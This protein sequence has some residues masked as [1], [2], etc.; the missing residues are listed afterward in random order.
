MNAAIIT[1]REGSK[2]ILDKNL[3]RI[4]GE[5]LISYPVRAAQS[6]ATVSRIF[7]STDGKK[8]AR[9]AEMLGCEVIWRPESVSG[10]GVNHG[11]VIKQ[12]VNEIDRSI[13][14]LE[15]VVVLLGN[16]VMVDG[17]LI[18]LAMNILD[19]QTDLDSVMSVWEAADDHPL[20][21]LEIVDDLLRP[22][23]DSARSVSTER[24]S[25]PK[26]YFYDQGLWAL[27]KQCVNKRTGPNPWWWMGSRVHPIIRPWVTGRD[28]HTLLDAAIAEWWAMHQEQIHGVL[29]EME[30]G[31]R[32]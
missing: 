6:A 8:I 31:S 14:D 20:R 30:A 7:V 26:A 15:N 5:P 3:Y 4:D 12:A 17:P 32:G 28:I 18:D 13:Q 10:D 24:Q 19:D 22:Y 11:E 29:E 27:R 23:G 2:S 1:A 16:T 25:Y 21:A 9:T